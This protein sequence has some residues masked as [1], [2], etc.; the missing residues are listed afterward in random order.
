MQYMSL[1]EKKQRDEKSLFLPFRT[2]VKQ[3]TGEKGA[4]HTVE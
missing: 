1:G 4:G 2:N 3:Q